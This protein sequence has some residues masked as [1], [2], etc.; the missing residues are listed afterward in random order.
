MTEENTITA[1]AIAEMEEIAGDLL[2]DV[3]MLDA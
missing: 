1:E 2:N 3:P